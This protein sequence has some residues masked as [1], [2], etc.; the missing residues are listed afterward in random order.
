[1]QIRFCKNGNEIVCSF[2]ND[3]VRKS[4]VRLAGRRVKI[5]IAEWADEGANE[6]V[7][8]TPP[9][10]PVKPGDTPDLSESGSN[11]SFHN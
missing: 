3:S 10:V 6:A 2:F 8:P 9:R 5:T 1:M 11:F 4:G 7:F